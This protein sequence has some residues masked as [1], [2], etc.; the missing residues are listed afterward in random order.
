[1]TS[2]QNSPEPAFYP[3]IPAGGSGKRLWPMSRSGYPKFMLPLGN[4]GSSLLRDTL[5]RLRPLAPE[6]RTF[7][8]TGGSQAPLI[9]RE[10]PELPVANILVEPAP[11]DSGPA[12]ALAAAVIAAIDPTA[13]MG[14]FAADHVI[15]YP[16]RF[17]DAVRTAIE[18]AK[19]GYLMTVGIEPTR[20]ETGY[21][22]IKRAEDGGS[23]GIIQVEEF[24]EKPQYEVAQS[25][26]ESGRYLWNASFFIWRVDVFLEQIRQRAPELHDELVRIGEAWHTDKRDEV[27]EAVWPTL[28]KVA[29]EYLLMEPAARDGMVATVAG[30]FGW[31]DVGDYHALGEIQGGGGD[32]NIVVAVDAPDAIEN[33][34]SKPEVQLLDSR[35]LVVVSSSGR[36]ISAIGVEDLAIVDTPD[37]LL[38]CD[39]G[40]A[41]DVKKLVEELERS[42]GSGYL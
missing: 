41:Q 34:P 26:V 8:V 21:G 12:I 33:A 4:P 17:C 40:R 14:S 11:R 1:V 42:G 35:R 6:E 28:P 39:R 2:V 18:G 22:Y 23:G 31:S 27:L 16:D 19:S 24:V 38:V 10:L 20:P 32:E 37:V 3:V 25:Y 29:I 5:A 7:V 36:L 9:A 30:D 13:V 15:R